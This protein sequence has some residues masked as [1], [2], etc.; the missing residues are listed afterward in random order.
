MNETIEAKKEKVMAAYNQ[1]KKT[2]AFSVME[3]LEALFGKETFKPRDVTERI[4]TFEDAL[5]EL[6][7]KHPMVREW[8][9]LTDNGEWGLSPDIEAYLKLRIICAALNEGWKPTFGKDEWRYF[10]WFYVYFKEELD[11]MDE[12][13]RGR[14]VGRESD[15]AYAHGGL[16]Y[17]HANSASSY[18]N[19][20]N[21]SRLA[22]KSDELAVYCGKQFID[23]WAD[24]IC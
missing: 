2:N 15:S 5:E 9:S 4:K 18:S 6:G 3:A 23:I 24:Y 1:A 12:D 8:Q 10:P 7:E 21:G 11:E 22:L 16:V 19:S 14:V 13:E 17:A 20:Y